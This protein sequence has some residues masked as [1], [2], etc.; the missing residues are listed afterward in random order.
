VIALAMDAIRS[1]HAKINVLFMMIWVI[2]F[3]SNKDATKV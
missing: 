3:N 1:A 2:I